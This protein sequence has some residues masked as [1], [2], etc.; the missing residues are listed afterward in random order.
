MVVLDPLRRPGPTASRA[1]TAPLPSESEPMMYYHD[2]RSRSHAVRC[3]VFVNYGHLLA[4]LF[5]DVMP[6][7]RAPV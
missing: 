5:D 1:C 6:S 4:T 2:P 7:S 3:C